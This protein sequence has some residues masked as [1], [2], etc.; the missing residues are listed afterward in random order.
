MVFEHSLYGVAHYSMTDVN[1]QYTVK[2]YVHNLRH[3]KHKRQ[4]LQHKNYYYVCISE[5][6]RVSLKLS[7]CRSKSDQI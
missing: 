6:D 5:V 4:K 1:P 3:V 2:K 7:V